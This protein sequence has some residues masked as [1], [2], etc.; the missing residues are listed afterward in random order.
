VKALLELV[1]KDSVFGKF[2]DFAISNA[3][4]SH[5]RHLTD[6]VALFFLGKGKRF[7]EIGASHP[8]D[9]SDT[10]MLESQFKWHGIQV[11]PNP[12][13]TPLL[14]QTRSSKVVGSA[15]VGSKDLDDVLYLN[16]E[17]GALNSRSGVRVPTINLTSLLIQHGAN[18][19][20][21]FIDIEGGEPAIIEE[22][23][24][25]QIPFD[26]IAI[27]RIWNDPLIQKR[28]TGLGYLNIYADISGYESWWLSPKVYKKFYKP[29][30]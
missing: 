10:Y 23:E 6:L 27:E 11:E 22:E 14:I 12:N 28:L 24:F 25:S 26:F 1:Q 18:Y 4:I 17:T 16:L 20:A 2:L 8:I 15:L 3:A 29:L 30:E 9:A 7:L 13:L 21:L 19:D 5:S